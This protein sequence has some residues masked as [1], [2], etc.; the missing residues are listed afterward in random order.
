MSS[1]LPEIDETKKDKG[2]FEGGADSPSP[3]KKRKI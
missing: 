2:P 1:I 3:D